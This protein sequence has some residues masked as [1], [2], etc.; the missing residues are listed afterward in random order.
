MANLSVEAFN[1]EK[2]ASY[3]GEKYRVRDNG[4]ICR[5]HREGERKRAIDNNWT[6][7]KENSRN[8]Y[9]HIADVRIH[10]IVATAFHGDPPDPKYVVDQIDSNCRNN[11]PE[12]LRWLTRLENTLKNPVTRKKIEYLC[13]SVE[14][15]LENPSMLHDFNLEPN[16]KWMRAVTPEEASNCK[17]RME[18]WA[19]KDNKPSKSKVSRSHRK[20]FEKR[21]YERPHRWEVGFGREPGLD[22]TLTQWCAQYMWMGDVYLPCCPSTIANGPIANY[23]KNI[24]SGELFAHSNHEELFPEHKVVDCKNINDHAIVVLCVR[25]DERWS[26]I[27]IDF[28]VSTK[29]FIHYCIGNYSDES[30][31][32]NAFVERKEKGDFWSDAYNNSRS[33]QANR[34][35]QYAN[36]AGDDVSLK[37]GNLTG[38]A[39]NND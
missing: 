5:L 17:M 37:A 11:R 35:K 6:F 8:P 39:L 10:R 27:G 21:V 22:L 33:W 23:F 19:A 20:A 34:N 9:L 1:V 15:F 29:H 16:F 18:I 24:K 32:M 4:A 13:G 38:A 36:L 14:A 31:A 7:G 25:S 3:N 2:E 28:D 26:L 12:N 30:E